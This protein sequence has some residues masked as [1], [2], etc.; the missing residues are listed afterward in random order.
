MMNMEEFYEKNADA[1]YRFLLSL[2]ADAEM[3]EELT[4]ETLFRGIKKIA[5]FR[6]ACRL[7]TWLCAI[8]RNINYDE[9]RR[10]GRLLPLEEMRNAAQQDPEEETADKDD[11][12][13]IQRIISALPEPYGAVFSLR[14][15]GEIPF[16]EISALYEKSES[17]ARVTFFRAKIMITERLNGGNL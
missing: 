17:W 15:L 8:A 13:R 12:E 9:M 5:S 3:A 2:G 7:S 1:V 11:A 16:S 4:A 10:R 14:V 6:E